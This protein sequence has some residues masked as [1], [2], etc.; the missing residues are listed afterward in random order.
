MG[1]KIRENAGEADRAE[2]LRDGEVVFLSPAVAVQQQEGG[3]LRLQVGQSASSELL[4]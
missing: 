4:S 1:G 3:G 2:S